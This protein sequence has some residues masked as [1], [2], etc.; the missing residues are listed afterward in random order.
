MRRHF[1]PYRT[2][3][4]LADGR[5]L[6]ANDHLRHGTLGVLVAHILRQAT[7]ADG[8]EALRWD[9]WDGGIG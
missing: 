9:L 6:D 2:R 3:R 1:G 7:P 8:Q 4:A 5:E